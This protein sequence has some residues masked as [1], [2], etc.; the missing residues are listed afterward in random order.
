MEGTSP[1]ERKSG[2]Q[3]L[4]RGMRHSGSHRVSQHTLGLLHAIS[5]VQSK[6]TGLEEEGLTSGG[7][8]FGVI[9]SFLAMY[10]LG[11][12]PQHFWLFYSIECGV[13]LLVRTY[14]WVAL[15]LQFYMLD[16]CWVAN[17]VLCGAALM[18]G[19]THF[20]P[21]TSISPWVEEYASAGAVQRQ[22][23]L[24]LFSVA[25][26]PL[27]WAILA[28]NNSLVFHSFEHMATLFIHSFPMLAAWCMRW[29]AG[30][31][32]TYVTRPNLCCAVS[33]RLIDDDA[34]D[35]VTG[36]AT[37]WATTPST[38]TC[39]TSSSSPRALPMARGGCYTRCG[40][41]PTASRA[42]SAGT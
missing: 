30:A 19:I 31:R 21:D 15:K 2:M 5:I 13:L 9:N 34:A 8:A 29:S 10:V 36:T 12:W 33:H 14:S 39:S 11:A 17:F 7:F 25:T 6:R 18:A 20:F 42:P 27:A 16:F 37:C 24:V 23:W 4:P 28:T 38:P 41:A 35:V 26:G 3:R 22:C 1:S 40:C 32:P